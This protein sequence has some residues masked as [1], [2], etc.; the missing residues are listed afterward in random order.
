MFKEVDDM[1]LLATL[2]WPVFKYAGL[3]HRQLWKTFVTV[4]TSFQANLESTIINFFLK[5]ECL[6]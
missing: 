6:A 3:H 4:K 1:F 5:A 2:N